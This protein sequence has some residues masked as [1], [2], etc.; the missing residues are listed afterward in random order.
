MSGSVKSYRINI[1]NPVYA[2]LINDT[3]EAVEY[4][5]V[6]KLG[7]AMQVQITPSVATGTLHGNGVPVEDISRLKGIAIAF[8]ATKIPIEERAV[9]QGHE[10]KDGVIIE[11]AGD[12]APYIA[13]GYI[14]E[15]SNKKNE[16][17]WLLKGRA[18]PMNET[19]KQSEDNINFSTDTLNANFIPR[20]KDGEIRYFAD[21]ANATFT[22]KQA[23]DWF[24]TGPVTYPKATA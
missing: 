10:F 11:K 13:F 6:K 19:H 18:T 1:T 17:V 3:D 16:Y 5:T 12:E 22:E 9:I 21:S 15:G 2:V 4:G 24:K 14:I 8:D 20:V 7:E 23:E